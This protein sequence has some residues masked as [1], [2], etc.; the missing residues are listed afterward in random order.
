[1]V[2]KCGR[3]GTTVPGGVGSRLAGSGATIVP[4]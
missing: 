3:S 1:M 4:G 2:P